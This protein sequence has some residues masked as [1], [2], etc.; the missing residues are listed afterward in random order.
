LGEQYGPERAEA[1]GLEP[2]DW[3][4]LN[5]TR[6][7]KDDGLAMTGF[8]DVMMD[9]DGN[10]YIVEYK[11]RDAT[12][13]KGPPAQMS[14]EWVEKKLREIEAWLEK[15]RGPNGL[16]ENEAQYRRVKDFYENMRKAQDEGR[17][18]GRVY[19]TGLDEDDEFRT[20]QDGDDYRY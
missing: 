5:T 19:R 9:E 16:S 18:R 2:T 12:L 3:A 10:V 8:D 20:D 7:R 13:D 1:D 6:R 11:G 4:Y 15:N 17:L 14:P